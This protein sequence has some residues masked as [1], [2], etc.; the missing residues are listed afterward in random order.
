MKIIAIIVARMDSSRLPRKSLIPIGKNPLIQIVIS[1]IQKIEGI[2]EIV[3][4]TTGR[5]VDA[6]LVNFCKKRGI[7][8]FYNRSVDVND[9][10]ARVLSCAKKHNADYFLR[11]NG[12]SPFIDYDL[13]K[14][15]L[16]EVIKNNFEI[17]SNVIKRS[18]PYGISLEIIKTSLLSREYQLMSKKEKE[19][20]TTYFYKEIDRFNAY[21]IESSNPI[22]NDQRFVIDTED[23]L[24]KIQKLYNKFGDKLFSLKYSEINFNK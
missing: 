3:V 12:D 20:I 6:P 8:F 15:G 13:V 16:N 18:F 2:S 10:A 14:M 23:D 5:K 22:N 17:V 19:H 1:H 4:A 11:V 7:S 9:V 24:I 21:C